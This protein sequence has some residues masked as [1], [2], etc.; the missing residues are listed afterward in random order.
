M[1]IEL[2]QANVTDAEEIWKMQKSAFAELFEK[3]KDFDTSPANEPLDKVIMRLRQPFTYFYFIRL[4]GRNIGAIRVVDKKPSTE[5]KRISPLFILPEF[6]NK[7]Y[8]QS[9]I[10]QAENI[11]GALNWELE[12]I[13]QESAICHLYEKT[14]Y[15]K[16]NRIKEI[17]TNMTLI[18]Y[19][20]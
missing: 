15:R 8:A 14:G 6:R 11:H 20:K 2:V 18:F 5:P 4:N 19:K 17:N 10:L 9:A 12:T 3:Y 13:L 1:S 7:G 16:T